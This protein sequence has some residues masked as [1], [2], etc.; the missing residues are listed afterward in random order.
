MDN[1][2]NL[3]E[4]FSEKAKAVLQNA[5]SIAV[6]FR[7]KY[8]D[9]EHILLALLQDELIQKIFEKLNMDVEEVRTNMTSMMT[10]GNFSEGR[11]DLAPRAKQVLE[12][13]FQESRSMNHT[14]IGP[15]H[16]LLGLLS[17]GEGLA[18]QVLK[19]MGLTYEKLHKV[20]TEVVGEGDANKK[21]A[22]KTPTLDKFAKDL[23]AYAASGKIDPVIGRKNEVTRVIQ[24]LS[25]RKKNNP[26][27]IGDPGVGKTAI[28]EGLALKIA[29]ENVPEILLNKRVMALDLGLL[30]AGAKFRGEFEE[31]AMKILSEIQKSNGE[32]ILFIDELHTIVGT[33]NQE[34][35]LDLSN[36]LKPPL[37]R[38]ELQVIG[39]TTLN[40]YQK[41]IEKDAAL[42]RRF[43]P[44]IVKEPSVSET[45]DILRGIVDKYESHH[46][47]KISDEA[48]VAA[49][50]LSERYI[51]DRFLPDKA[52]DVI[53]EGASKLRLEAFSKPDDIRALES[54]I[55]KLE[56]ERES[57]TRTKKYEEAATLKISID[58]KTESLKPLIDKWNQSRGTG[59]PVLT[60]DDVATIISQIT[61]VPVT[62]LKSEER[63]KLLKLES[64]IHKTL[65][66]QS[67]AV[68]A[69]AEAV[70]RARAGL[71]NPNRP[72]ASFLF[73]GPT[74]VGKTELAKTLS[75]ILFGSEN[76]IVRIDMSE[77]SEKFN[78]SKLIG[79]PP[80]YVGFDDGG[81]L[82]EKI[83]RQPYSI[84][85]LDE[86]EKAHPEVFNSLLQILEDGRL[87][88][89]K[90]RVVDFKNTI[91]IATSNIGADIIQDFTREGKIGNTLGFDFK[92]DSTINENNKKKGGFDDEEKIVAPKEKRTGWGKVKDEVMIE[93]NKFF[94]P[95]F[96]NRIDEI[97]I[98][99]SLT[100][101]E[102]K[103]IVKLELEKVKGEIKAQK[104]NVEFDKSIVDM[105]LEKGFSDL[106]G[107]REIR[108][109]IQ[110]NIEN[111]LSSMLLGSELNEESE[112]LLKWEKGKLV[113]KELISQKA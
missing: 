47:I 14:Y 85:L 6:E 112:Y 72:I 93:L 101:A 68:K 23:T 45:I 88:D 24:I 50:E 113:A 64:E 105:V 89:G 106:Y 103:D 96:L 69:V 7:R 71:K 73:L 52:I 40:E 15:E 9:T 4:I 26:V 81:Q 53:D 44:I 94:K 5:A 109:V 110:K 19:S 39:A 75:K 62:E 65:V 8:I 80:G 56:Q 78:V 83:R 41:Y 27:L 31:R 11:I 87:T 104:I 67:E 1:M 59:T 20:V 37:A 70:R 111:N 2:F 61:S 99:E 98:F 91:V 49:S 95:E 22:S 42:E 102:I 34:G 60:V 10:A 82:T 76:A 66:G 79:S 48:L 30:M 25:R 18:A 58:K 100:K 108:R 77:Y 38:G 16:I 28:A 21:D 29:S 51:T 3:L 84:I 97:I 32:V 36:I 90:G 13:T 55:K 57:L 12:I 86:I 17:E 54:E 33:G 107:A 63:K 46:R 35:G 43:Q 74:G 92:V